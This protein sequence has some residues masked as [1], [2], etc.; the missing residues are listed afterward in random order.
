VTICPCCGF[1]FAGT[2]SEGCKACGARSVG[3]ALPKPEHELPFYGRSL[4]LAVT[5]TLMVL[6]FLVQTIIAFA[7]RSP[8][9]F[10]PQLA[11]S[12]I[13]SFDFTAWLAAAETAAWRLK[14][15]AI[16]FTILVLWG[17]RKLYQSML[18]TPARFCGWRYARGGMLASALVPLLIAILIGVTIPERLRH[19]QDGIEA[20]SWAL[21]YTIGRAQLEYQ[22]RFGTL[23]TDLKNDLRRLPDPDGSIAAALK[24]I[25]PAGYKTTSADV[26]ALPK[27]KPQPLRASVIRNASFTTA[28]DD[29]LSEG[30]SFTNYELRLP[31]PD[32]LT[33]TED[34]L[35]LRDGLITRASDPIKRAVTTTSSTAIARP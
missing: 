19:R 9:E 24:N 30:L 12:S 20:G 28:T 23:P 7:Q 25:D 21:G 33:G 3:E 31:G 35:I 1:S 18:K 29:T 5:G 16:P 34:D 13:V 22:A 10:T 4:L 6:V 17:G 14:W 11:L 26:A 15:V 32:K 27:L 8:S 2:L